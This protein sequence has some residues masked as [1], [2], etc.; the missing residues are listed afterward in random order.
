MPVRRN[1]HT[2]AGEDVYVL[3]CNAR[4]D[5]TDEA[6]KGILNLQDEVEALHA[7]VGWWQTR[8]LIRTVRWIPSVMMLLIVASAAIISS[9]VWVRYT[10]GGRV[11]RIA[12]VEGHWT[13]KP[14]AVSPWDQPHWITSD[15]S[16][17]QIE[18]L[19][20]RSA[21]ERARKEQP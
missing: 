15:M 2:P 5:A 19:S 7:D 3:A 11:A 8:A 9:V 12:I 1:A 13:A 14:G 21:T 6:Y 16:R 4:R 17:T 10:D 18:E 20:A